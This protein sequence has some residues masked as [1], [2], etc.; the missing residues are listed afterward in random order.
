MN[1]IYIYFKVG[2]TKFGVA[3]YAAP[4]KLKIE[5]PL[6]PPELTFE[7]HE[8]DAQLVLE[9]P[10]ELDGGAAAPHVRP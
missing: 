9:A 1:G 5:K 4:T 10:C 6:R 3:E 8:P 2:L 7:P